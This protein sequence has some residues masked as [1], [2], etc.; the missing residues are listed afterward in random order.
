MQDQSVCCS[1]WLFQHILVRWM[2]VRQVS[3]S[4]VPISSLPLSVHRD[5]SAI[6]L[7]NETW[8]HLRWLRTTAFKCVRSAV[9]LCGTPT[10]H[11]P[12]SYLIL[13]GW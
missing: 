1:P 9:W 2:Q 4:N 13:P 5:Q 8:R 11:N 6:A 12:G 3:E 10:H 7:C